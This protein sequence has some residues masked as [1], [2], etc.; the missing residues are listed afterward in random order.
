MQHH[1]LSQKI[2]NTVHLP[3]MNGWASA[4]D[5]VILL[6]GSKANI[7]SRRSLKLD[8]IFGSSPADPKIILPISFGL[9]LRT[10]LV[11]VC[12]N[13]L[14]SK[15]KKNNRNMVHNIWRNGEHPN[16]FTINNWYLLCNRILFCS[17]EVKILVKVIIYKSSLHK[18]MGPE[19]KKK[20]K[21]L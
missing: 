2:S 7:L 18:F 15:L 1:S 10:S 17:N 4:C 21:D 12:I 8:N 14:H 20:G 9:M 5:T 11:I 19:R 16:V 3:V 13:Q 6:S